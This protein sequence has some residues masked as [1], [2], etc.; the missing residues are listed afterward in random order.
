MAKKHLE[1][2]GTT[3]SSTSTAVNVVTTQ[4]TKH[5]GNK[6]LRILRKK[7]RA[8]ATVAGI[9]DIDDV[10]K[11]LNQLNLTMTSNNPME[12]GGQGHYQYPYLCNYPK[13][14][15]WN[16]YNGRWWTHWS[17][18]WWTIYFQQGNRYWTTDPWNPVHTM[19]LATDL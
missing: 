16:F 18:T 2:K 9:T 8:H 1:R 13:G 17:H 10:T 5:H 3:R 7:K 4:K 11:R 15:Y 19:L 6:H 12:Y 14:F